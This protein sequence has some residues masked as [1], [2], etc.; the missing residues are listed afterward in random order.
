[1]PYYT[2]GR[3]LRKKVMKSGIRIGK[4]ALALIGST[5]TGA[6]LAKYTTG[7][8][9]KT[10][11]KVS[12]HQS[13][14][15]EVGGHGGTFSNFYYVP[16]P[17]PVQYKKD[18]KALGKN[19]YTINS[20]GRIT[21]NVGQQGVNPLNY[22]NHY[23][24]V[25]TI[26]QKINANQTNKF[27]L[28]SVSSEVNL[29]NQ[30]AGNVK[31][32]LYDIMARRDLATSGN[33]LN[34]YAAWSNSLADEGAANS[35]YNVP[36]ALPY[37]SDLFTQYFKVVKCTHI[38][39]GQGQS[40]THRIKFACNKEFDGEYLQYNTNG[41]KGV[42][43][44]TMSVQVGMPYN[45]STTKTQVSVGSTAIDYVTQRQYSYTWKQDVDTTYSTQQNLP[46]AFS[47]SEDIMNEATG[48]A[49]VD[50]QA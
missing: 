29:T 48:T 15:A 19:Y 11:K 33:L 38:T 45:D 2:R 12:I 28:K 23:Q 49:T 18:F 32:I 36:G 22:M 20:S 25:N 9:G 17:V 31:V 46:Q 3:P 14:K 26:S 7:K 24:D 47:V 27:L 16:R 40:H 39:L 30:D 4:N 50:T 13:A 44:F 42:T 43:C 37:S 5:T 1:M 35:N 41:F 10:Y 21:S 8:S 34:P 6:K